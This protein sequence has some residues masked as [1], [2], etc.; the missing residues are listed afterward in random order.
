MI[1]QSLVINNFRNHRSTSLTFSDRF[2]A[3]IG[4]NGQG[5]TSVLEAISYL[6]LTKSFTAQ[7]DV[8]V[9]MRHENQFRVQGK[10]RSDFGPS[11]KRTES[12]VELQYRKSDGKKILQ[13]NQASVDSFSAFI[14]SYPAVILASDYEQ[15]TLGP[16]SA[17]RRF[18]DMLLSQ[19]SRMYLEDLMA[20]RRV[21]RNRNRVLLDMRNRASGRS[22]LSSSEMSLLEPWDE[23]LS[24][25]GSRIMEKRMNVLS[26]LQPYIENAYREIAGVAEHPEVHYVPPIP[27][28]QGANRSDL[29]TLLREALKDNIR[30]DIMLGRTGIGPHLDELLFVLDG[31]EVRR[32]ASRGQHKTFLVALKIAEFSY[33][34]EKLQE[35]PLLLFDDVIVELDEER[36][37]SLVS[38]L[39]RLGQTFVSA[40]DGRFLQYLPA[41][42]FREFE[43]INGTVEAHA[44]EPAAHWERV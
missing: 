5:K 19:A 25:L 4:G 14:G 33:L 20:Y 40:T 1:L 29:E 35:T 32:Y 8:T 2:N 30:S 44:I 15:I 17:R 9:V 34:K 21:Q 37:K 12:T 11:G 6:C 22:E 39:G 36:A 43:V 3:F 28:P 13:V 42:D 41:A 24:F 38:I 26:E 27:I 10:F 23:Q 16:P 31:L 7:N 18:L